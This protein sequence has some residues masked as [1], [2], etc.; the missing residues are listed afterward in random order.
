MLRSNRY[1]SK[2]LVYH[3]TLCKHISLLIYRGQYSKIY[4]Q[5]KFCDLGDLAG[6]IS[7]VRKGCYCDNNKAYPDNYGSLT[8]HNF[9]M[10]KAKEGDNIRFYTSPQSFII[11][12]SYLL[13]QQLFNLIEF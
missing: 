8:Q 10:Q 1:E 7:S 12:F 9:E 5:S 13:A 2:Q 11:K 4:K 6:Q 3:L